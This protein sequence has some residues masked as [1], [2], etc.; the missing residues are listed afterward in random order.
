MKT[1]PMKRVTI[2]CDDT[3]KYRII[4]ELSWHLLLQSPRSKCWCTVDR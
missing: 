3:V 2:S 4:Q 1:V